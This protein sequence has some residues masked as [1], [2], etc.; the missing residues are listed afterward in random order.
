MLVTSIHSI[1]REGGQLMSGIIYCITNTINGKRY[2]GQ[3]IKMLEK[4]WMQHKID[5]KRFK[6][7]FQRALKKYGFDC[8]KQ[9]ILEETD[10]LNDREQ[11]WIAH[12]DTLNPKRGY[13][14]TSGGGQAFTVSSKTKKKMSEN[15]CSKKKI[16]VHPMKDKHHSEKTKKKISEAKRNKYIGENNP[17]HGKTHTEKTKKKISEAKKGKKLGKENPFFGKHHSEETK[18][19]IKEAR[20]KQ[21]MKPRV[22]KT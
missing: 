14:S 6:G 20:A 16:Y 18:Q 22:R 15:H 7:Y 1:T 8:W 13:N 5:S 9:E 3:T 2:V 17:F 12:Y 21:I 19:R 10:N 11:Y 4:R